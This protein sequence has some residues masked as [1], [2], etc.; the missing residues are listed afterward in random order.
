MGW[1]GCLFNRRGFSYL[2]PTQASAGRVGQNC[3][4]S[5]RLL[6][7]VKRAGLAQVAPPCCGTEPLYFFFFFNSE[8]VSLP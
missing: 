7:T 4:L 2:L 3:P 5:G 6:L 8:R 1:P